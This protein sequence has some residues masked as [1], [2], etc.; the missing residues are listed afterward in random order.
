MFTF[1]YVILIR[2][3]RNGNGMYLIYFELLIDLSIIVNNKYSYV[4][5]V[6]ME[7]GKR[8]PILNLDKNCRSEIN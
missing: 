2:G 1:L 7:D 8:C 6:L 4:V 5:Y 3:N